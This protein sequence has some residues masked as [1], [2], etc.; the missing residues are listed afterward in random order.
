MRV[1]LFGGTFDPPH[2]GHLAVGLAAVRRFRLDRLLLAPTGRQPLKTAAPGASF[3]DRLA[4][5]ELL[6]VGNAAFAASS[7]DAPHADGSPN[8]TVDALRGLRDQLGAAA[9]IFVVVG[10][11]AFLGLRQW[12]E[13]DALLTEA[14]WVVVSRPGFS[15]DALDSLQLTQQQQSRVHLIADVDVPISST[16]LRRRLHNREDCSALLPAPVLE[17]IQAHDLYSE[18]A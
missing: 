1:G 11:D 5:V 4:M 3:A 10:A 13:P 17:Y 18:G 8:Y 16:E 12:R 2:N 9:G 15:L 7:L 14:A 6:C